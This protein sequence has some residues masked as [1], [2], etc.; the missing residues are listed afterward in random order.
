MNRPNVGDL[1]TY[2]FGAMNPFTGIILDVLEPTPQMPS[3][4]PIFTIKMVEI[5]EETG[6][7]LV[8]D[9]TEDDRLDIISGYGDS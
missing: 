6:N 3:Y 8:F 5:E 7:T 1:V 4:F 9:I 2:Y